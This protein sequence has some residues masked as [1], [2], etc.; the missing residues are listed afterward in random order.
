MIALGLG[1]E[2]DLTKVDG[3]PQA[4][5]KRELEVAALVENGLS[6]RE[7]AQRLVIAKRTADGH[8]ERILSK[9]GFTSRAQIAAWMAR[10]RGGR[11]R[12]HRADP[13]RLDAAVS[14]AGRLRLCGPRTAT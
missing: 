4:L 6:N 2:R 13:A 3:V 1:V 10:R 9:L 7:I 5:T 12:G 11:G 8:V 14:A